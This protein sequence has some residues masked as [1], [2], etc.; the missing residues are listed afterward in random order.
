MRQ[1]ESAVGGRRALGRWK[2]GV[3]A[4][5]EVRTPPRFA[6]ERAYILSVVLRDFLGLPFTIHREER[7]DVHVRMVGHKGELVLPD[8]LLSAPTEDW[9]SPEN[10][11]PEPLRRW[12]AGTDFPEATL[13]EDPL[14]VLYGVP[15]AAGGWARTEDERVWLGLDVFG[16][17]LFMLTRVEEVLDGTRDKHERFP[18][19]A[20]LALRAG[21]LY[22]PLVNEYAEILWAAL[23]RLWPAL[24]RPRRTYRLL[25]SHDVDVPR[26]SHG[27]RAPDAARTLVADVVKRN[28]LALAAQ[29]VAAFIR[30]Y[31]RDFQRDP[32][33]TFGW[34]MDLAERHGLADAFYFMTA[35][36][37]ARYDRGYDLND[38]WV[39]R[40][41][42]RISERGHEIG[43]HPS[44]G[45]FRRPDLVASE[46]RTLR[47]TMAANGIEQQ[48][49]GG[50]QH[51]LRWDADG[52][53]KSWDDAG[54]AYDSSVGFADT[55]GFRAGTCY[56]FRTFDLVERRALRLEERP[57]VVM[58]ATMLGSK[59]MNL[60]HQA[61]LEQV[62]S[63][64]KRCRLFGGDFTL[65]WHNSF[66]L[67]RLDRELYAAALQVAA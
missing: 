35:R 5:L 46:L 33:N 32:Y 62:T 67:T 44:Y 8:V 34:I 21:F 2:A 49:V 3:V 29:R 39:S 16:S 20:S 26:W 61:A 48:A 6:A 11:P 57:L 60:S 15:D 23:R 4:L 25:L 14:P 18:A 17:T 1:N 52:S 38:P 55:V 12:N 27:V 42:L 53:W 19:R 9:C 7:T 30:S 37:D 51:Y 56:P 28:D 31:R 54:L 59:Y 41:L 50:R 65:L 43:L 64:S 45:T 58:D 47:D 22:R 10:L 24:E 40:L 36:T 66:L 63:M 13:I